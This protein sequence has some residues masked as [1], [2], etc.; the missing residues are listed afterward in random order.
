MIRKALI[1]DF[2]SVYALFEQLWPDDKLDKD[3]LFTIYQKS[4]GN[5]D[6]FSFCYI[7][8]NAILGFVAGNIR[9]AF[10]RAGKLCY[11]SVLVTNEKHRGQ[12]VGTALMNH[13][14][15]VAIENNCK[16]IELESGLRREQAHIF[17]ENF[18]FKKTAYT[19]AIELKTNPVTIRP[20]T[21]AD[22]DL[23][24]AMNKQLIEDEGHD[25]PMTVQQLIER[26]EG[27]LSR[28]YTALLFADSDGVTVGYALIN[29]ATDPLYLRQFFICRDERRKGYGR[30]FFYKM[31]DYL[32]VETIDIEVLAWNDTGKAF[33]ESLNFKPRSVY[34]RYEGE[35]K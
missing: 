3:E 26:M 7:R 20:A 34:M 13:I 32:G 12:G 27:F 9:N 5:V 6:E 29:K 8:D 24:A 17:Y 18:G 33:W 4:L 23:L 35:Q 28:D 2:V 16:A 15:T 31:L 21:L 25:N 30:R 11:V 19:F 14:E 10:Y 22:T 1:N